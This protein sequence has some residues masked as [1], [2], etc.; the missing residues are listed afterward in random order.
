MEEKKPIEN[1]INQFGIQDIIVDLFNSLS[2]VR[3]LSELNYHAV[4]EKE[5]IKNALS[6]L[7]HN[8]DMERCSFFLLDEQDNLV[9]VTGL[10]SSD[11]MT[12]SEQDYRARQFKIGEGIIGMA[13]KSG[14]LQNCQNCLEDKNFTT[15]EQQDKSLLPGSIIS[16][17][18][19]AADQSLIGI[20]NISHPQ[21]YY[22]SEWHIR[23]LEIYKNMLGQMIT[24][25]RLFRTMEKQIS[26]RTEKLENAMNDLQNLKNHYQSIS[27]IDH[28][29]GLYNR[30]YFFDYIEKSL[31]K[32]KR[33]GQSL[34]V[35]MMDL[36]HFKNVN[37]NH[38]HGFGD[39]VLI[40]VSK[41]LKK[42]VRDSD[43]LVRYG[44]EEFIIIFTNI[45]AN[46]GE[47]FAER[48][49]KTIEAIYWKEKK[50]FIQTI[51]I[52][53]FYLNKSYPSKQSEQQ[54]N[55]DKLIMYADT[56]LYRAKKNGRNRVVTFTHDMLHDN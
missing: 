51:S 49:R 14:K 33:Y 23:L 13:A 37:D 31:S 39:K 47:N 28:L 32:N 26:K 27:M 29:T 48:I 54:I 42:H 30:R 20:L 34:C 3:E 24:N 55:I 7:I 40:N 50:D 19:F 52:G 36:D 9:N 38:G 17:P 21:A 45:D 53:L 22:F 4:T 6:A 18:V 1:D 10:S 35:L 15:N 11:A 5:L 46:E 43:I 41:A 25:F 8:Q 56:A 12:N 2:A 16:V 44:G